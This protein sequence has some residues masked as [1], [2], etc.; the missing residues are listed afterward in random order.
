MNIFNKKTI[1]L[2]VLCGLFTLQTSM[3]NATKA[4]K[5]QSKKV[6]KVASI[7]TIGGL[8]AAAA[9]YHKEYLGALTTHFIGKDIVSHEQ[10]NVA[11]HEELAVCPLP[12][13]ELPDMTGIE[14]IS[15]TPETDSLDSLSLKYYNSLE[16]L[17]AT[18]IAFAKSLAHQVNEQLNSVCQEE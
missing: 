11:S 17:E 16:A 6:V 18:L 13:I 9:W 1:F 4:P 10:K 2:T 15:E 7:F 5:K 12:E 8:L 3:V 14:L